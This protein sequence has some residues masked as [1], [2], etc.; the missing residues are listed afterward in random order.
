MAFLGSDER[1]FAEAI[2][3]L[4]YCNPFLV[5]RIACEREALGADF[6]PLSSEQVDSLSLDEMG[7]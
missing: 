7:S 2:S 5:E 6:V 1:A 4:A 3:R